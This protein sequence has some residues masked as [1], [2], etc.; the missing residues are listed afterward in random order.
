MNRRSHAVENLVREAFSSV[1]ELRAHPD[2]SRMLTLANAFLE[3]LL[4]QADSDQPPLVV[5]V[6]AVRIRK[7]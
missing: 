1:L 2:A 3:T 5:S 4:R 6:K 7:P